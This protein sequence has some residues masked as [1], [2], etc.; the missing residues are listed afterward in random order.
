MLSLLPVLPVDIVNIVLEYQGY[1]VLRNG[2]F[3]SKISAIDKRY[4]MLRTMPKKKK[5]LQNSYCVSI[6]KKDTLSK[7]YYKYEI[8]ILVMDEKIIW[9]MQVQTSNYDI[10]KYIQWKTCPEKTVFHIFE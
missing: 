9:T 5:L 4:E 3:M 6:Y 7:L 2:K 1:H 8:M 10:K